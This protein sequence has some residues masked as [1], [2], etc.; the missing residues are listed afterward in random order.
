MA[1]PWISCNLA[2]SA[3]GKISSAGHRP[4]TWTSARDHERLLTLR[5]PAQALLVGR[6]TLETDQMTLTVPGNALQPLRC[7]VSR[8]GKLSPSHPVFQR[9]GGEIHLLVTETPELQEPI[10]ATIHQDTLEGFLKTLHAA[11]H[12]RHLHCEGGGQLIRSLAEIDAIDEFHLTL[13]GHTLLGGYRSPTASGLPGDF[14]SASRTFELSH[15]E[16]VADTGECFLSYR[17]VGSTS[18]A[19]EL[20]MKISPPGTG[21][22]VPQ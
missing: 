9:A 17:R 13:A 12:V 5:R 21:S 7:I 8:H 2:V 16:P 20:G 15:F 1:R 6:G 14:L 22:G 10:A 4:S 3:D 19:D 11:Y 18:P